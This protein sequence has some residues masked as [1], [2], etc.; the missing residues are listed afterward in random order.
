MGEFRGR[1]DGD[2]RRVC[3]IV[4]Q[5][6]GMVTERLLEGARDR[7]REAGVTDEDVDVLFVPGAWELAPVAARALDDDYDVVVALGCVVRGE[8]PHFD[9]ICEAVSRGLADLGLRH[10]TPIAFGVITAETLEQAFERAGGSVGNLG[11]QAATA[12]LEMA[13]LYRLLDER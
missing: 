5:F 7:L 6:N 12:A 10:R 4:S 8:T 11:V 13:D 1:P 3:V 9:Y 2:G